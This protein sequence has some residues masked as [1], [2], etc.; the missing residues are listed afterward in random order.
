VVKEQ[1]L[2]ASGVDEPEAFFRQSFDRAF[3]HVT[4]SQKMNAALPETT[5][6]RRLHR[7]AAIVA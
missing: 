1:I 7:E 6:F 3:C 4:L 2:T 5:P